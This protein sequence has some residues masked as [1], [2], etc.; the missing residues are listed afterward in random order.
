LRLSA[1]L[2]AYLLLAT[3]RTDADTATVAVAANFTAPLEALQ[4]VF[5]NSSE[6]RLVVA[7]GSTGQLYAQITNGA[8]FDVLLAADQEHPEM[9]AAAGFASDTQRFTYAIGKLALFT[10][11]TA[12]FAPLGLDTLRRTDYRWLAIANPQLAPYGLA[13]Q[14]ALEA[15]DLWSALQVR[16]VRGQSIAQT[17]AMAET[18]NAELALIALSQ[19]IAYGGT[20]ASFEIPARLY[21][22]IRQDA[23][24]LNRAAANAAALEFL[25]FLRSAAAVRLIEQYGYSAGLT[26]SV[27][28]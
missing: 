3:S 26:V 8:P 16:M 7:S 15:L 9:L 4:A 22:P 13:A 18:R 24:L 1:L 5:E 6:H 21:A 25:Q 20:A 17:F 2:V 14:Q 19:A 23:I 12:T 10:R 28:D 27:R 11:D